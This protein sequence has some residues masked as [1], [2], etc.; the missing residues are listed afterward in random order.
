MSGS[1]KCDELTL[2]LT[3]ERKQEEKNQEGEEGKDG[4]GG[5]KEELSP[6]PPG[7]LN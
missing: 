2:H 3:S 5:V 1:G 6:P 7:G 4:A